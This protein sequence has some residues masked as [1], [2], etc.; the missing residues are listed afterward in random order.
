MLDDFAKALIHLANRSYSTLEPKLRMKLA[1]D[2]FVAG[3][4]RKKLF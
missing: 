1:L 2:Q 3:V 4:H